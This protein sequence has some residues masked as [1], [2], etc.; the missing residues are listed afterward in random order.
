MTPDRRARPREIWKVVCDHHPDEDRFCRGCGRYP[1]CCA[2][3]F[4]CCPTKDGAL[5]VEDPDYGF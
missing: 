5:A 4:L 1:R 3:D 2:N